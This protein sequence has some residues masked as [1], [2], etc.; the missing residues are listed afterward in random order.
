MS[1][2]A[3]KKIEL[4][5]AKGVDASDLVAKKDSIALKAQID[6]LDIAKLVNVQNSLNNLKIKVDDID[7]SKVKTVP[8]DL[9]NLSDIVV[10]EVFKNTKLNTLKTKVNNVNKKIPDATTLIHTNQ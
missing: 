2:H 10:N 3:T 7:I 4:E 8:V 5:H 6:K 9:K 1:N